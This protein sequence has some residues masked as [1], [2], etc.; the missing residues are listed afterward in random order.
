[1]C[2]LC[3]EAAALGVGAIP[4]FVKLWRWAFC[5]RREVVA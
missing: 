3:C 1:M 2:M 4:W 5:R